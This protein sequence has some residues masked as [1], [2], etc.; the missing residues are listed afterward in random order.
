MRLFGRKSQAAAYDHER[1]RLVRNLHEAEFR[2]LDIMRREPAN[3][4]VAASPDLMTRSY[5]KAW[6]FEREMAE[7]PVRAQAEEAALVTKFP[8]FSDFELLNKRHFVPYSEAGDMLHD[9]AIE[10]RYHDVSRMLVF[11]RRR[12]EVKS[13]YP[14]PDDMEW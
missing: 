7:S 3:M 4:I 6:R 12:D 13:K 5:E 10:E 11:M 8:M 1:A 14:V 9:V 2:Y